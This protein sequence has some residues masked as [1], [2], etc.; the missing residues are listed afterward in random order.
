MLLRE[1]ECKLNCF[2]CFPQESEPWP[3]R[4]EHSV[5]FRLNSRRS[6]VTYNW[7]DFCAPGG[8]V[9]SWERIS[10]GQC[11]AALHIKVWNWTFSWFR[12]TVFL[13]MLFSYLKIQEC[14][15]IAALYIIYLRFV[16]PWMQMQHVRTSLLSCFFYILVVLRTAAVEMCL[17]SLKSNSEFVDR[18]STTCH[19]KHSL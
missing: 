3:L 1:Y 11:K 7:V 2:S 5:D 12:A 16:W 14:T 17:A 15:N 9:L 18:N 4:C 19:Y 8:W 10:A 13:N 6:L